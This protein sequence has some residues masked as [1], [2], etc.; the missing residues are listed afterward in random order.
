MIER[1]RRIRREEERKEGVR[2][3]EREGGESC[4]YAYNTEIIIYLN[5]EELS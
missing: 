5:K 2:G 3:R 4:I 1:G